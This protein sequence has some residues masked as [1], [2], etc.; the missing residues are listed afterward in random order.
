MT[1]EIKVH[2]SQTNHQMEFS[3]NHQNQV[4]PITNE[5]KLIASTK[6]YGHNT[7]KNTTN[8]SSFLT[9][10]HIKMELSHSIWMRAKI[11]KHTSRIS[12]FP[13]LERE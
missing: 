13:K 1:T 7:S 10:K 2:W 5:F 8:S 3:L 11:K 9:I 4:W 12:S 6:M